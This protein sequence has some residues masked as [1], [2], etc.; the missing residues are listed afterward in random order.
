[1]KHFVVIIKYKTNPEVMDKLRPKHRHYLQKGYGE[2]LLLVSGPQP[3][4]QG[5]VVICRANSLEDIKL[6]FNSDPYKIADAAEY[7]FIEF[8]PVS[9]QK[10]LAE[11]L[12]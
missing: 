11:W 1:M 4:R 10:F 6:F 12:S 5:G 3:T 9:H 7:E 8:T 2:K